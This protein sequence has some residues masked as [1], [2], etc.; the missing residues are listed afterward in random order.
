MPDPVAV[1][2][3]RAKLADDRDTDENSLSALESIAEVVG[4]LVEVD[5]SEGR[6]DDYSAELALA[7]ADLSRET[8]RENAAILGR[9]GYADVASMMRK[10]ARK[11]KPKPLSIKP[12]GYRPRS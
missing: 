11:A 7:A 5:R 10:L 9:L 12:G 2:L 3:L 1:A 6:P 4:Y 8:L